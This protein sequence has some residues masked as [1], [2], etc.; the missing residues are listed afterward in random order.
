MQQHVRPSFHAQLGRERLFVDKNTAIDAIQYKATS[1][2]VLVREWKRLSTPPANAFCTTFSNHDLV[3]YIPS[4]YQGTR[5]GVIYRHCC[6]KLG[7]LRKIMLVRVPRCSGG[8]GGW[9][10]PPAKKAHP[11]GVAE[12]AAA[13]GVGDVF[14]EIYH[15][16]T[17][18][19]LQLGG[20]RFRR[21]LAVLPKTC[22]KASLSLAKPRH[23]RRQKGLP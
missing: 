12:R 1:C 4:I 21:L 10:P 5:N 23:A 18:Y 20:F 14:V 9:S 19:L 15:M 7:G 3:Q 2:Y 8:G 13:F 17:G 11:P 22:R 6:L 16:A